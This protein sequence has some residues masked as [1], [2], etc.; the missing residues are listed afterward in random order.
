MQL[1]RGGLRDAS[2]GGFVIQGHL[3]DWFLG[4]LEREL[5]L[6]GR[7][8]ARFEDLRILCTAWWGYSETS[9]VEGW[10]LNL[11]LGVREDL[12]AVDKLWKQVGAGG[13]DWNGFGFCEA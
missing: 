10:W 6:G 1:L 7:S 3:L 13:G 2:E 11:R 12:G 9:G 4:R 8:G 5:W